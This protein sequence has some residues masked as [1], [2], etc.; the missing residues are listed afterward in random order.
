MG[1][2]IRF[3][4]DVPGSE[5]GEEEG[6]SNVYPVKDGTLFLRYDRRDFEKMTGARGEGSAEPVP[7]ADPAG[8]LF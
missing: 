7:C 2:V 1:A 8:T 3:Y 5:A 4:R 6:A